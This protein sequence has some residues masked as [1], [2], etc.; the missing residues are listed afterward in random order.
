MNRRE[1]LLGVG[2]LMTAELLRKSAQ[3]A[4]PPL[5]SVPVC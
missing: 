4:D 2:D 5:R 3:A 1:V